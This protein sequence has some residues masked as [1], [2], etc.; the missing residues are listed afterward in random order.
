MFRTRYQPRSEEDRTT[1]MLG[2]DILSGSDDES[3]VK[4]S[5]SRNA[6]SRNEAVDEVFSIVFEFNDE[7]AAFGHIYTSP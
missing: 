5:V 7:N 3:E 2:R 4:I 6:P 1:R